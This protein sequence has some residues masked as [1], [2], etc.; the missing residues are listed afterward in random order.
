VLKEIFTSLSDELITQLGKINNVR[1]LVF[2]NLR[3][4]YSWKGLPLK[5]VT[6]LDFSKHLDLFNVY[7]VSE[8]MMNIQQVKNLQVFKCPPTKFAGNAG[9]R[10]VES[11]GR[12][13]RSLKELSLAG[14]SVSDEII[15]PLQELSE[16]QRVDLSNTMVTDQVLRLGHNVALDLTNCF[17]VTPL[18][19]EDRHSNVVMTDCGRKLVNTGYDDDYDP[20][21]ALKYRTPEIE[22][23]YETGAYNTIGMKKIENWQDKSEDSVS[24][25]EDS[26]EADLL[27]LLSNMD[28]ERVVNLS[29]LDCSG[30]T[31]E[32]IHAI[33]GLPKLEFLKLPRDVNDQFIMDLCEALKKADRKLPYLSLGLCEK[34]TDACVPSLIGL[35]LIGLDLTGTAVTTKSINP[36]S[37]LWYMARLK[38]TS[39]P[40]FKALRDSKLYGPDLESY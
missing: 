8:L 9:I 19:D 36:I 34:I 31:K 29:L 25:P 40:E 33:L 2:P 16:L 37:P 38:V 39:N 5:D 17:G 18:T 26:N 4:Y 15:K 3:S 10:L 22:A 13:H 32:T 7:S 11:L 14:C 20:I 28:P 1:T 21:C 30:L 12:H 27:L 35:G 23:L 6:E 24:L